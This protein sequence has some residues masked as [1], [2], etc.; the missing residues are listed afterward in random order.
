MNTAPPQAW[1]DLARQLYQELGQMSAQRRDLIRRLRELDAKIAAAHAQID[2]L[3]ATAELAAQI[4]AP[5][6]ALKTVP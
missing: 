3:V 5:P 4:E 2:H 1:Q 6:A